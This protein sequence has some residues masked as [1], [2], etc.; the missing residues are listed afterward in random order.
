MR[1][2]SRRVFLKTSA[3]AIGTAAAAP[4]TVRR[5][6][7]TPPKPPTEGLPFPFCERF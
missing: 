6:S 7:L 5:G 4:Y 1:S 3:A 2:L